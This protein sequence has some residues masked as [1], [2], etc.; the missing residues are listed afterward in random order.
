MAY[1]RQKALLENWR[2]RHRDKFEARWDAVFDD[3]PG[4]SDNDFLFH[5]EL[6][7]IDL[8]D[9]EDAVRNE[10]ERVYGIRADEID[11]AVN[12]ERL[13][14]S[15]GRDGETM[16]SVTVTVGITGYRP[17]AQRLE[18]IVKTAAEAVYGE[19]IAAKEHSANISPFGGWAN[20]VI[21]PKYGF[22]DISNSDD[23]ELYRDS[24]SDMRRRSRR[25][26]SFWLR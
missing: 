16:E 13:G 24:K 25:K 9:L 15:F 7:P 20:I 14:R 22:D 11:V 17:D 12:D 10:A 19:P 26:S 6:P 21:Y 8:E 4:P 1:Q 2:E 18:R 3:G 23:S 5:D